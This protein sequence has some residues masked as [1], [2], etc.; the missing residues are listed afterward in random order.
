MAGFSMH[1]ASHSY[2]VQV[3]DILSIANSQ[4]HLIKTNLAA[5][6]NS[7]KVPN[8]WVWLCL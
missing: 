7:V 6:S 3:K 8:Q 1:E 4:Q 2:L 5:F